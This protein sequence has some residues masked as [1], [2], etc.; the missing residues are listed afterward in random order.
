VGRLRMREVQTHED[1]LRELRENRPV[2]HLVLDL[3]PLLVPWDGD[4]ATA[5]P[6]IEE[7]AGAAGADRVTVLSNSRRPPY[8]FGLP[9]VQFLP[10]ARKPWRPKDLAPFDSGTVVVGD[11]L[12][13]DGLLAY[14][15]GAR[16]LH[17]TGDRDDVPAWPRLQERLGRPLATALGD[18]ADEKAHRD[19]QLQVLLSD[20][21]QARDDDRYTITVQSTLL[22]VALGFLGAAVYALLQLC[23]D[24]HC[25]QNEAYFAAILPVGPLGIVALLLFS[26]ASATARGFYLRALEREIQRRAGVS[27]LSSSQLRSPGL[28]HLL[29]GLGSQTH[30]L[31]QFRTLGLV[32]LATIG[33]GLLATAALAIVLIGPGPLQVASIVVY[34]AAAA[35]SVRLGWRSSLGGRRLFRDLLDVQ[36]EHYGRRLDDAGPRGSAEGERSLVS[37]L[38]LPRPADLIKWTFIPLSFLVGYTVY[39]GGVTTVPVGRLALFVLVFEYLVYMA[40]YQLNDVSGL[41]H[42]LGDV[43]AVSRGRLPT[44]RA[45]V[46]RAVTFSLLLAAG[47]LLIAAALVVLFLRD[48]ERVLGVAALLVFALAWVYETARRREVPGR[49]TGWAKFV[50]LWVGAGYALRICLGLELGSGG[51]IGVSALAS[52]AVAAWAFGIAFVAMTWALEGTK[53]LTGIP[54]KPHVDLLTGLALQLRRNTSDPADEPTRWRLLAEGGPR[55]LRTPWWLATTVATVGFAWFVTEITGVVEQD[56]PA[57]LTIAGLSAALAG[58]LGFPWR[59]LAVPI[60][61]SATAIATGWHV[62]TLL[63]LIP[64]VSYIAF[65]GSSFHDL[66]HGFSE[67]MAKLGGGVVAVAWLALTL[68]VG[69]TTVDLLQERHSDDTPDH[70][71]VLDR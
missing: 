47:R 5:G 26:G 46:R 60:F 39:S 56:L 53:Q 3:E 4:I 50:V 13:T 35:V 12:V 20:Y 8:D 15:E 27:L 6:R 2:T 24:G 58:V 66:E 51:R 52:A 67:L 14:R 7:L 10:R 34:G 63:P 65:S 42:D 31:R 32:L 44:S 29:H 70:H 49:R 54:G 23:G 37:Y 57:Y 64:I 40:R 59:W 19:D 33:L 43:H 69:K 41:A 55:Q 61:V 11:V 30:G 18:G 21:E 71:P 25:N 68:V 16:F 17:W 1:L 22:S 62:I 45:G 28:A 36:D 38:L 9:G 48:Q